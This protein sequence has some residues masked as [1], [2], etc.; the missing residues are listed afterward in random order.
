MTSELREDENLRQLDELARQRVLEDATKSTTA[1]VKRQL[2]TQIG[3]YLRGE[4]SGSKGGRGR[5]RRRAAAP[6]RRPRSMTR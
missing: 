3:A 5:A 4:L 6:S 1:K 2:A